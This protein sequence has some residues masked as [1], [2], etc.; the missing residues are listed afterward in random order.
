MDEIRNLL[1]KID[2]LERRIDSLVR[3]GNVSDVDTSK[4]LVRLKIGKDVDGNDFK[5]P[6]IPYAQQAGA[7]KGHVPPTVG[8]NMTV[9]APNGEFNQGIAVPLSWNDNNASPGSDTNNVWTFGNGKVEWKDTEIIVTLGTSKIEVKADKVI[10]T[11]EKI[12]SIGD[13]RLGLDETGEGG[14]KVDTIV[15]PAKQTYAKV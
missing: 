5:S 3:H 2:E 9:F 14:E 10:I 4:Q 11:A 1:M 13:T 15:G 12:E 8:Q 6:W 7:F